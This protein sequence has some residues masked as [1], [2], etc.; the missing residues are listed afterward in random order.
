[1]NLIQ[2]TDEYWDAY[3]ECQGDPD[4]VVYVPIP[5]RGSGGLGRVEKSLP[6]ALTPSL[7]CPLML[8]R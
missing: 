6:F 8:M 7:P 5:R 1:M 3:Q 2:G 4:L